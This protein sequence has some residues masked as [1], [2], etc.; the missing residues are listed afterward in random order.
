ME[1][2]WLNGW[3]EEGAWVG[4]CVMC[5][6]IGRKEGKGGWVGGWVGNCGKEETNEAPSK[7]PNQ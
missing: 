5:M 6:W 3:K 7:Q 2:M 4:D 1:G